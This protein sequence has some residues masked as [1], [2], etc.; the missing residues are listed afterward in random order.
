MG[1]YTR[2]I[3]V[4]F[5]Q[6]EVTAHEQAHLL[7]EFEETSAKRLKDENANDEQARNSNRECWF[8]RYVRGIIRKPC[9]ARP[10]GGWANRRDL[11]HQSGPKPLNH[12]P[13]RARSAPC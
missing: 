8:R 7:S 11:E 13:C 3:A 12:H 9:K 6:G 5:A 10:R 1:A 2:E 4:L